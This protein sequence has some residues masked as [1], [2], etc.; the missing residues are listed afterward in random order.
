MDFSNVDLVLLTVKLFLAFFSVHNIIKTR[1]E[2]KT[3][4]ET[5]ERIN[6]RLERLEDKRR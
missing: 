5:L 2:K 6:K 1:Q 4:V 3:L